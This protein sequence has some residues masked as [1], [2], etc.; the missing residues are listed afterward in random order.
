MNILFQYSFTGVVII[1][2]RGPEG[3]TCL[4]SQRASWGR[5]RVVF[6]SIVLSLLPHHGIFF[7]LILLHLSP[8]AVNISLIDVPARS[9]LAPW[10]VAPTLPPPLVS[11]LLT[12]LF[13]MLKAEPYW[14]L[15]YCLCQS[16][17]SQMSHSHLFVVR[18]TSQICR[19]LEP[20]N[21][22][23]RITYSCIYNLKV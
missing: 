19:F 11:E 20:K 2:V 10:E 15:T 12:Y 13:L 23:I 1:L 7:F 6:A 16:S 14:K 4:C 22:W 5:Q 3:S 9:A 18:D 17:I 21:N 8:S